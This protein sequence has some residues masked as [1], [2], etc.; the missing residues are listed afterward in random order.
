MLKAIS[1]STL[2][3]QPVLDTLVERATQLC[4]ADKGFLF[5]LEDGL[6]RLKASFGFEQDFRRFIE[7]NPIRPDASG[8]VVGRTALERRVLHYDD[9]ETDERYTWREAQGF[10]GFR[11]VLGVPLLRDGEPI[12]VMALAR[13]H[14]EPFTGKQIDLVTVFA[15]QAVIAI[16]NARLVRELQEQSAALTTSVE[17]LKALAET[18]QAISGTLDLTRVLDLV[19]AT[20]MVLGQSR[21]LC[22]VPLRSNQSSVHSVAGQRPW[23]GSVGPYPQPSDS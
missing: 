22:T 21:R 23:R 3:L 4:H 15:D 17:E 20:A 16:E 9:V 10:G 1:G 2:D 13:D 6:Y 18:G 5:R 11:T 19:S 8:T 7:D 12:G 14:V